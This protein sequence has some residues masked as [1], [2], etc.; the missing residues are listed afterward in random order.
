MGIFS[1][2]MAAISDSK[3]STEL[4][5]DARLI[6]VRTH[7]E[8]ISGHIEGAINLPLDRFNHDVHQVIQDKSTPVILYC[9][10]G[11]RSGHALSVMH[12]LGYTQVFNGGGVGSLALRMKKDIKRGV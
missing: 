12:Q 2:F 6:D 1:H 4:P 9:R 8:Y 11:A 5:V 10:S 7:S 3:I